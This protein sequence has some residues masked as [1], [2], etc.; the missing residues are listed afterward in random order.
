MQEGTC[1]KLFTV[2]A[3][4]CLIPHPLVHALLTIVVITE[5]RY[6]AAEIIQ[7]VFVL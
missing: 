2:I 1:K 3:T 4:V 5:R 7:I 6:T